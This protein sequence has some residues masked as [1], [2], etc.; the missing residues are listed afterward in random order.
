MWRLTNQVVNLIYGQTRHNTVILGSNFK[1]IASKTATAT[2]AAL[3]ISA[4][5]AHAAAIGNAPIVYP[6][7]SS[8]SFEV[9]WKWR[10]G[11]KFSSGCVVLGAQHITA[12]A[13][14]AIGLS[15]HASNIN[16]KPEDTSSIQNIP[17]L[18]HILP[19]IFRCDRK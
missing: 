18:R 12:P 17:M 19:K 10:V 2:F 16:K 7:R 9:S 4:G 13:I 3:I 5:S 11:N 1:Q 14:P 8:I 6:S 15:Q